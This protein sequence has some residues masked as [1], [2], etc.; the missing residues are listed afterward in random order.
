MSQISSGKVAWN[1]HDST[2]SRAHVPHKFSIQHLSYK[3]LISSRAVRALPL[4]TS[5]QHLRGEVGVE[6][7]IKFMRLVTEVA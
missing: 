6:K 3:L 1:G 5:A 4:M 2:S 7:Q